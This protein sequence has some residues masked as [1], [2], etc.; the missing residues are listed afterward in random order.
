MLTLSTVT[1]YAFI[2][3]TMA[4]NTHQKGLEV[5]INDINSAIQKMMEDAD[6]RHNNYMQHHHA[7]MYRIERIEAQLDSLQLSSA[8][9]GSLNSDAHRGRNLFGCVT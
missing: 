6:A 5:E 4:E 9:N 3:F 7:D 2:L 8:L 1:F